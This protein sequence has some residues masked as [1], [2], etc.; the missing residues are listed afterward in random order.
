[1]S[2]LIH[3]SFA[4][5]ALS[6]LLL[7]WPALGASQDV[8]W[9]PN[10]RASGAWVHDGADLLSPQGEAEINA[11]IQQLE[12]RTGAEIAVVLLP[13]INGEVP[14][15]FAT[16]LFNRWGVGQKGKDNGVLVLHVIDQRRV[17]IEVGYGLEASLT[18]ARCQ[19]IL[20]R[21]TIPHLKAGSPDEAHRDTVRA[22]VDF[23]KDGQST[24]I[25]EKEIEPEEEYSFSLMLMLIVILI[26]FMTFITIVIALFRGGRRG[27]GVLSPDDPWGGGS[28]S[29][30]S[31][32]DDSWGGGS[33]S[34]GSSSGGRSSGGGLFGGGSSGGSSS[35]GR[36]SGSGGSSSGG[37]S[38]GGRS[39]GG[40]GGSFG[41]GS[42]GGGGAGGS[43]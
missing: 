15:D 2:A 13:G 14:R 21:V 20:E 1:M 3:Q 10:P 35:G 18:D 32:S 17:E 34:G 5:T 38:S 36:S 40:G 24:L 39:S 29:G 8:S 6:A 9:V 19:Q 27:G 43:Y 41:G 26:F 4:F 28:S 31:L 16:A 22:L 23:I 25:E 33:S 12:Q 7:L 37:S 11:Q 30:G 42:S